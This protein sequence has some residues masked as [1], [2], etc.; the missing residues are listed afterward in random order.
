MPSQRRNKPK[1]DIIK[2]GNPNV[3]EVEKIVGERTK[4]TI[5]EYRIR[6]KGYTEEED[7]WQGL[8]TLLCPSV[9]TEWKAEKERRKKQSKHGKIEKE[10]F[11]EEIAVIK[12]SPIP[13]PEGHQ[14]FVDS[15]NV[16]LYAEKSAIQFVNSQKTKILNVK[17]M[18][19]RCR[20]CAADQ[21]LNDAFV[22]FVLCHIIV[23]ENSYFMIKFKSDVNEVFLVADEE[24]KAAC[25]KQ[26]DTFTNTLQKYNEIMDILSEEIAEKEDA[27]KNTKFYDL[28]LQGTAPSRSDTSQPTYTYER[29]TLR[30]LFI[31]QL[32]LSVAIFMKANL[33]YS[34]LHQHVLD[35][36]NN[37]DTVF[38]EYCQSFVEDIYEDLLDALFVI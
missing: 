25:P 11:K 12:H 19:L 8:G 28:C 5:K 31:F 34:S 24:F 1:L 7:T 29:V 38:K 33:E 23:D 22:D 2:E 35:F 6:W 32:Q 20:K 10:D 15:P 21:T 14:C 4:G 27:L 17:E 36:F 16:G 26:Y 30:Q 3:Y 18:N 13:P 37:R 9:L